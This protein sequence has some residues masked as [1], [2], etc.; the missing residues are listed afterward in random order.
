MKSSSGI[1]HKSNNIGINQTHNTSAVM[2]PGQK[3]TGNPKYSEFK[4]KQCSWAGFDGLPSGEL[5]IHKN[6]CTKVPTQMLT[7]RGDVMLTFGNSLNK[8]WYNICMAKHHI[9]ASQETIP[10]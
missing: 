2:E 6:S 10:C 1:Q 4:Q 7:K 5:S 9:P 3:H 8:R